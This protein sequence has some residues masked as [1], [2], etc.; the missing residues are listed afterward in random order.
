MEARKNGKNN[1]WENDKENVRGLRN[2]DG[3]DDR[4]GRA[5]ESEPCRGGATGF[6]FDV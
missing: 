4:L 1:A 3:G 5:V 2:R 6:E